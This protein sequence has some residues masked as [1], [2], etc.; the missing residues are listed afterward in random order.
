M[1]AVPPT[2]VSG[3]TP[4]AVTCRV[5]NGRSQRAKEERELERLTDVVEN[6]Y[7][8]TDLSQAIRTA[9]HMNGFAAGV[10]LYVQLGKCLY[11][12][13][14]CNIYTYIITLNYAFN[15]DTGLY[16]MRT[17]C[18]NRATLYNIF[19]KLY[20]ILHIITSSQ[21]PVLKI[22]KQRKLSSYGHVSRHNNI[23]QL[24]LQGTIEGKRIR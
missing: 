9:C 8:R 17:F 19:Y 4:L 13:N 15:D 7:R 22:T 3:S 1:Y 2:F 11:R 14:L 6:L 16:Y 5:S 18:S 10:L 23:F 20:F 12:V 21:Q 24:L